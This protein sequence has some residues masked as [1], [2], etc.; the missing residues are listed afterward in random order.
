MPD[1]YLSQAVDAVHDAGAAYDANAKYLLADKQVLA[2]ILKY[3]V[4]EFRDMEIAAIINGIGDN[5]EVGT[6][7]VDPGLSGTGRVNAAA[8][9]DSVPGEGL[10]FFRYPF[11]GIPDGGRDKIS[12]KY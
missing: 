7:P 12:G 11:Y 2:R 1:T 8:T 9:E 6:K 5:I 4:S 3:A 10:I